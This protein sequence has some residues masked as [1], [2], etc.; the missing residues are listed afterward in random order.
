MD[1]SG[2]SPG[3]WVRGVIVFPDGRV[4]TVVEH[5]T[6]GMKYLTIPVFQ[7][8]LEVEGPSELGEIVPDIYSPLR[9]REWQR[10]AILPYLLR[11]VA[12]LYSVAIL[13][14]LETAVDESIILCYGTVVD[15]VIGRLGYLYFNE[16]TSPIVAFVCEGKDLLTSIAT[17][18][19][20]YVPDSLVVQGLTLGQ[21]LGPFPP[22][23]Q[24]SL[25]RTYFLKTKDLCLRVDLLTQ[26]LTDEEVD[27]RF[28]ILRERVF[29][30]GG[31]PEHMTRAIRHIYVPTEAEWMHLTTGIEYQVLSPA[32]AEVVTTLE[33]R[34][35]FP[36][37]VALCKQLVAEWPSLQ[38]RVTETYLQKGEL[39]QPGEEERRKAQQK[40]I[41]TFFRERLLEAD[42]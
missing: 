41:S 21:F 28:S 14:C 13:K 38:K 33:E 26:G 9:Y 37:M 12:D 16:D 18:H 35:G 5:E 15:K 29:V 20:R 34:G 32:A 4:E 27:R 17:R 25:V 22:S 8:Y 36:C 6:D 1:V 2:E 31:L 42:E 40:C 7:K 23:C 10:G 11:T 24:P 39:W 19:V 3:Y 30:D